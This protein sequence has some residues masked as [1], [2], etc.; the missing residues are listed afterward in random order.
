MENYI[1]LGELAQLLNVN[2]RT[3][4]RLT[5]ENVLSAEPDSQDKRRKVYPLAESIQAYIEHRISRT[6]NMQR[7]ERMQELE[8][9]KLAAE[10]ELKESQRDLHIIKTE[11][12]TGKYLPVEQV[13]LDY[14]RFFVVLKK[15]LLAIPNR[16]S[17]QIG[18]SVDPV[19]ARAIEKDLS[20]E[21]THML[22]SFVMA[23]AQGD[24][25]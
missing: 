1:A 12:A 7:S 6:D 13:Q 21:I 19:T 14:S 4:Q 25:S 10:T 22:S 15:F 9:K 17:G 18:S 11:I 20:G 23:G 2:I 16:I 24:N 3:I 8:E 5:Q